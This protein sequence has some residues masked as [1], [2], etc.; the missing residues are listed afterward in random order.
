MYATSLKDHE[1]GV[2]VSIIIINYELAREIENCL[3]SLLQTVMLNNTLS[4]E[5]IIIDNKSSNEDL[6]QVEERFRSEN[7]KY[8]YLKK[9]LGFGGGCNYGFTKARG[10]YICFLNPDT[11]I[12]EN[13]FPRMIELFEKDKSIGIIAPQQQ[14]RA[15]FFDFSAGFSPNVFFELVGL[16]GIGVFFEGFLMFFYTKFRKKEFLSVHWILGACIFIKSELF[17]IIGGFDKDYFMFFEEVDLCKR[18]FDRG[19]KIAYVPSLSIH[20]V[21]SVSGKR[22]Y[23]LYTIRTYSSK[24][25]YISKHYSFLYKAIMRLLLYLQ[26]FSQISIW[27]FIFP[28]NKVKSKQKLKAFVYLLVNRMT[29]KIV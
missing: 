23:Y 5:I 28:L 16:F 29:N 12:R 20:H 3:N 15:P 17:R 4:Y 1:N 19:L 26:L 6:K 14:V 9:N 22:D 2:D 24:Y 25:I 21:G 11:I 18:V 10:K 8:Y 13:I 7:I 27:L